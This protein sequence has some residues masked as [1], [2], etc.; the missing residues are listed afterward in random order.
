[1]RGISSSSLGLTSVF[2]AA[3]LSTTSAPPSLLFHPISHQTYTHSHTHADTHTRNLHEETKGRGAWSWLRLVSLSETSGCVRV[4]TAINIH[5]F[6]FSSFLASFSRYSNHLYSVSLSN[7]FIKL[8]D[9]IFC[10]LLFNWLTSRVYSLKCSRL[11]ISYKRNCTR[12][13]LT[14][15]F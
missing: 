2:S 6:P 12:Y 8:H 4:Y 14:A 1:M 15:S 5:P 13:F 11:H 3:V 7:H 10:L 9:S